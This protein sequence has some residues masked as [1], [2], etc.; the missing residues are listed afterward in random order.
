MAVRHPDLTC[1]RLREL[2]SYNEATGQFRWR[3][4]RQCVR[5]GAIAGGPDYKGYIR[6]K[7]DGRKYFAHRLAWLYVYGRWPVDLLDHIDRQRTNNAI[8]N[9]REVS[10][11]LNSHN[12]RVVRRSRVGLLGV[13]LSPTPGKFVARIAVEGKDHHLGTYPNAVEAYEAYVSA[14]R[15]LHPGSVF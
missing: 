10:N 2:L 7:V 8:A 14:K 13:S 6:I 12:Q 4:Q 15:R 3:I 11:Q 9:L 5:D 1:E